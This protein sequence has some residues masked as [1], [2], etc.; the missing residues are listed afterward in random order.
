MMMTTCYTV[1]SI[2]Y[3]LA[4]IFRKYYAIKSRPLQFLRIIKDQIVDKLG[5]NRIQK[6]S[7]CCAYLQLLLLNHAAD[8]FSHWILCTML[9]SQPRQSILQSGKSIP[10]VIGLVAI[11]SIS[12]F[13]FL[14][15]FISHDYLLIRVYNYYNITSCEK[16]F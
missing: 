13:S 6:I 4:V 3:L 12:S 16:D 14:C 1:F 7:V 11:N 2:Q 8:V 9:C 10:T 5:S 15:L